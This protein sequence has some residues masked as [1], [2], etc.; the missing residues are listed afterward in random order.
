[1]TQQVLLLDDERSFADAREAI[2]VRTVTEAID[3]TSNLTEIHELWLDFNLAGMESTLDYL[4]YLKTRHIS[5]NTFKV[6]HVIFHS[7]AY[8]AYSL[9]ASFAESAG[10]PTVKRY[11][12]KVTQKL[13]Y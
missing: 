7:A 5:G 4:R 1:M 13:I 12:G 11:E 2:I 6:N 3:T 10:L 8:E 9:V